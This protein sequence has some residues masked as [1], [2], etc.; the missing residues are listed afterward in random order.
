[1][2]KYDHKK[3]EKKWAEKWFK[4]K[5]FT[6]DLEKAKNPYYALFMFPYPSAEGLHIG[7]FYAFTCVD[8]MA[9]YKKLQRKDVFE[10]IGFDAFG[11][12]SEN[13]AL[14]IKETP[15]KMLNRTMANFRKQLR[16]AGL[17]CDWA[18]EIDTTSPEYYK[19]TQ[20]IF[21]KLF[22]K[23]LAYQKEALLNWCPSCKTVLADEQIENGVC[24]RCKT[25]PEKK[26]MKQWFLKITA[27]AQRLLD[28]LDD[29]D[30]SEIT[31]SAQKNWI[32][33]TEGA[34]VKFTVIARS[35]E[36]A[37]KQSRGNRDNN[38]IASPTARNDNEI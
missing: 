34:S 7:N 1:M 23:G 12:H 28:G 15:R 3:I 29:M 19:W 5:I 27:Y 26:I 20:W 30:W 21:T 32:G 10:P 35:D 24:E 38:E 11:M 25:I 9:K 8:V 16:S 18:R 31:K 36:G 13:Y 17:G 14:K 4:D 22:E 33:R 37:T 6:P 2:Y